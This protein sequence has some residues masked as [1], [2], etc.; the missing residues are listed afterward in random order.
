VP[1]AA[2]GSAPKPKSEVGCRAERCNADH[3]LKFARFMLE[4][5]RSIRANTN[6]VG[7]SLFQQAQLRLESSILFH[8][9]GLLPMVG[10]CESPEIVQIRSQRDSAANSTAEPTRHREAFVTKPL[11]QLAACPNLPREF[12]CFGLPRTRVRRHFPNL[13][14]PSA[15]AAPECSSSLAIGTRDH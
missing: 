13:R 4:F 11:E 2:P 5:I 15:L 8:G 1:F 14:R 3:A 7:S 6:L 12:G 9:M 10:F